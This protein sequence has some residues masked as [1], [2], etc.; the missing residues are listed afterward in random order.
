MPVEQKLANMGLSLPQ[1]IKPLASYVPAVRTGNLVWI[2]GQVPTQQGQLKARGQI[3][4]EISED[5]GYDFAQIAAL[6]ALAALK[7]EIGDLDNVSRIVRIT[8]YV[9]SSDDFTNQ[10]VVVD[11]AS[12]LMVKLFGDQGQ[13]ARVSVGVSRLPLD[14]PVEIEMVVEVKG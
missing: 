3:G 9:S 13:H 14:A 4:D 11:G 7:A 5:Q 1:T 10:P 2:S 8:G 6:N 12:D